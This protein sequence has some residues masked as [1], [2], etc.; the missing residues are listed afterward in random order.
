MSRDFTIY[1]DQSRLFGLYKTR[2]YVAVKPVNETQTELSTIPQGNNEPSFLAIIP[3]DELYLN[4]P[5]I[6][7]VNGPVSLKNTFTPY[8]LTVTKTEE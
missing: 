8:K 5:F 1:C 6:Q 2:A 4:I 3:K 7:Q